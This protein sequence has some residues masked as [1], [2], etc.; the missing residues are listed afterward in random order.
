MVAQPR[1]IPFPGE[2]RPM[3]ATD[4]EAIAAIETAANPFPWTAGIFADCLRVGYPAWVYAEQDL[5][6]GF[7]IVSLNV[8]ECHLLNLCV[9]PREQGRGIGTLLLR[10]ALG[11]VSQ[12]EPER[13]ILEVR[14]SN[15][16]AARL[17]H[18]LG[19]RRIGLRKGYYRGHD[20]RREDALV[21][22]IAL[23]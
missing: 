15:T 4:L 16:R 19:F 12:G 8:Y 21:L 18:D 23:P 6:Q 13:M 22:A 3:T 7:C 5:V 20:G 17:Y 14:A 2:I 10:H 11:I 9:A 1:I